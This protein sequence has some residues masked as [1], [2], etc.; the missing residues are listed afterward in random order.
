MLEVR[1]LPGERSR[2]I[3]QREQTHLAPGVQRMATLAGVA[4]ERGEGARLWDADGHEYVDFFAGVGVAS[5]GHGH[6]GFAKALADQAANLVVGSFASRARAEYMALLGDVRR[7]TETRTTGGRADENSLSSGSRRG[8]GLWCPALGVRPESTCRRRNARA[9]RGPGGADAARTS[10]NRGTPA[11]KR[12]VDPGR[13][14][15]SGSH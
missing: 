3:V 2:A 7:R 4:F 13:I 10:A 11:A 14:G 8:S 12:S 15:R 5:L 9:C 6:P 1:K